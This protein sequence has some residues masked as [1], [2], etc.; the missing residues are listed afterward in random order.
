MFCPEC[1]NA[2]SDG[3]KFCPKCGTPVEDTGKSDTARHHFLERQ[4]HFIPAAARVRIMQ[5]T[6]TCIW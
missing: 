6:I 3:Q 1:G 5:R 2:L 4:A